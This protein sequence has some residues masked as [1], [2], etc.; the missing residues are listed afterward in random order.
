MHSVIYVLLRRLRSP[1]IVLISVYAVTILGMTLVPGQ[2]DQGNVWYMDFF[3]AFY[4]VS[5]MGSTIGFGE[6]P[7]EFTDA[8]RA[9]TT[10]GIY[11]TVI[12][13]L[14]GIGALL[15][16]LQDPAFQRLLK[17][18]GFKRKLRKI[19][20]SYHLICG[21]G[22][23]GHLLVKA[24]DDAGLRSVVI[25]KD[26]E[27]ITMLALEDLRFSVPAISG[28]AGD[29]AMLLMAGL[30]DALDR[31]AGVIALTSDDDVNL[32]IAL[33]ANLLGG[34]I[35][36]ISRVETQDAGD[37]ISSFGRNTVINPYETFAGRLAL[38]LHSPGTF[39]LLQW[40]TGVPGERLSDDLVSPPKGRWILCGYG[41]FGKAVEKYLQE[42]GIEATLVELNPMETGAPPSAIIGRG[43]ERGT[44]EEAGIEDAMGIVAGTNNDANNL[45]ILM[46][47]KDLKPDL[48]TVGRQNSSQNTPLFEMAGLDLVMQSS[49]VIAHKIFAFIRTPLMESFV[50]LASNKPN[51]W[52]N[53]LVSRVAGLAYQRVPRLWEVHIGSSHFQDMLDEVRAGKVR[54]KDLARNPRNRDETLACIPL[55]LRRKGGQEFLTPSDNTLLEIGDQILFC[56]RNIARQS[57]E[58]TT[59]NEDVLHYVLTGEEHPSATLWKWFERRRAR[60]TRQEGPLQ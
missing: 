12:A 11:G 35:R 34:N 24:L 47:A 41:R 23:T 4:F 37:N 22:D 29:P 30:G 14:Y 28:D 38:A 32:R 39:I 17:E 10:V 16:T 54:L 36:L 58:W 7:Y 60:E 21:Y 6:V 15:S 19:G 45:S 2:D 20:G 48:F 50:E 52:A 31:C 43:T 40:L 5:F 25:D 27:A 56:G 53:E 46:T 49:S 8:Q 44:L 33:A 42:E 51:D 1:L 13:W 9:W 26:E 3:H 59:N 18:A 55:L 57:M